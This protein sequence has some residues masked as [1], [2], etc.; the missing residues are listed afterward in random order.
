[1]LDSRGLDALRR[2]LEA[3]EHLV[4]LRLEERGATRAGASGSGR[5]DV[6]LSRPIDPGRESGLPAVDRLV[7]AGPLARLVQT[8]DLDTPETLAVLAALAPEVD[9]RFDELLGRLSDRAGVRHLTGEALRNLLARGLGTR[10][11]AA[12]RLEPSGRLRTQHILQLEAHDDGPLAGRVRLNPQVAA[13]L[14]DRPAW[15]P[16][17]SQAFPAMRLRTVHGFDDLVLP[18]EAERRLR[19]VLDRIRHRPTVLGRWGFGAHHDN[20]DGFHVLFHGPPGTGKT[21]A[22]AVLGRETDLPVYRVDLSALVSKYIGETEKNLDRVFR[23]AESYGWVLFFDEADALFGRRSEIRDARDRF[24]N[25]QVSYLLQRLESFTGV[26]ILATNFLQN[27]DEAFQR[28]IHVQVAFPE[29]GRLQ[30]EAIWEKVLPPDLPL[31]DDVDL[32]ELAERFPVT[33]GE[34]RNAA[35]HAAFQAAADGGRVT[36]EHLVAGVRAEY[37]KAGRLP[38]EDDGAP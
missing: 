21:M 36:C 10:L 19:R 16:E 3:L 17:L 2:G 18:A 20:A 4:A 14:L 24:A 37:E 33:G 25:Q 11:Q 12:A 5:I 1:M 13:W 34:I 23:Q 8:Y 32:R 27:L 26:T 7:D 29:P 9:E 6:L 22:A 38:P 30:R 28:R 15:E 31:A 35:F